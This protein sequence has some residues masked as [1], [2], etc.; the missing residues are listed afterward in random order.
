MVAG[1]PSQLENPRARNLFVFCTSTLEENV[2]DTSSSISRQALKKYI[3]ANNKT[4]AASPAVFDAQFN[5][6]LRT[7]VEKG[8]F[9]Q[10]KGTLFL[11]PLSCLSVYLSH[12][13]VHLLR[14]VMPRYN[15]L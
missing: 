11:L 7:G 14:S 8:D 9:T 3:L 13:L 6:A 1:K 4:N 15:D 5:K 2:T 10:P 12:G